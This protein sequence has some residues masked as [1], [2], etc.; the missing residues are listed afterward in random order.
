MAAGDERLYVAVAAEQDHALVGHTHAVNDGR[1]RGLRCEY[2]KAY[3]Q[4]EIQV[5]SVKSLVKGDRLQMYEHFD[6]FRSADAHVGSLLNQFVLVGREV[7]SAVF[8]I[9]LTIR[10][11]TL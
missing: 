10:I 9:F 2:I 6:D 4:E 1:A 7:D 3:I 11:Y 8:E 5:H